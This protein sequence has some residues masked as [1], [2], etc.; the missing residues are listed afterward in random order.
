MTPAMIA[1]FGALALAIVC[2]GLGAAPGPAAAEPQAMPRDYG[3]P[4]PRRPPVGPDDRGR[5]EPPLLG[6]DARAP[7]VGPAIRTAGPGDTV[8]FAAHGLDDASR[9][10]VFVQASD[11]AG[12]LDEVPLSSFGPIAGAFRMPDDPAAGSLALVW[13]QGAGGIGRPFAVNRAEAWW[14]GPAKAEP[15]A[16]IAV[17]GR[18]LGGEAA[19]TRGRVYLEPSDESALRRLEAQDGNA[20]RIRAKLPEDLAPGRYRVWVHNGRGGDFGW[21]GPLML[22][23]QERSAGRPVL[24]DVKSFGAV[25]DGLADDGPAIARAAELAARRAPATL[26]LPKGTY[27]VGSVLRLPSGVAWL[28]EGRTASVLVAREGF[29]ADSPMLSGEG[30]GNGD[31][32]SISGLTIDTARRTDRPALRIR[33]RAEVSIQASQILAAPAQIFDLDGVEGLTIRY[34]AFTGR[35]G[36]LGN[37]RQVEISGVDFRLTDEANSALTSWGGEDLALV[38]NTIADLDSTKPEGTGAGRFFVSQPHKGSIRNVYIADNITKNLAPPTPLWRNFDQNAGEQILFEQCCA[39]RLRRVTAVKGDRIALEGANPPDGD[40]LRFDL[41][42]VSGRG[43]AQA[44]RIVAIDR[45]AGE[46]VLERPFDIEPEP[47]SVTTIASIASRVVIFRNRLDGK[48]TWATNETASSGVQLYG[49]STDVVVDANQITRM[50]QGIVLWAVGFDKNTTVNS[51]FFNLVAGNRIETSRDGLVARTAYLT[52]DAADQP[53]HVGNVFRDNRGIGLGRA[54]FA[55][56]TQERFPGGS[57]QTVV[58]EDNRFEDVLVGLYAGLP[59]GRTTT[60][61]QTAIVDTIVRRNVFDQGRA[62]ERTGGRRGAG[63]I[64]VPGAGLVVEDN[65]WSGFEAAEGRP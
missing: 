50:R 33:N 39:D 52:T 30:P 24:V 9:M 64:S 15:G 41:V 32:V 23:V 11:G 26:F 63:F 42:V 19:E 10:L 53:G 44:R 5:F 27:A 40:I 35:H 54:G 37:A 12:R 45:A 21:T 60:V 51:V 25:G 65:R 48:A 4:V 49:N 61:R 2:S 57:F 34:S 31:R 14:V 13:P 62:R 58:I 6:G 3:F 55:L 7:V 1:R 20:Y 18:N 46:L 17:Y 28:G 59:M 38:G 43:S 29:P 8:T 36:Y 56:L 22:A 16:T 47:G